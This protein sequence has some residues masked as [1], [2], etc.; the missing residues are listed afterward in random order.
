MIIVVFRF[1]LMAD[2]DLKKFET[3]SQKMGE[4]VSKMAGFHGVKDFSAQDGEIVVIA[5][6]DSL[7]SVDTWKS[8]PKHQAVQKLGKEKFFADYQIQV[9][10]LIRTQ[11]FKV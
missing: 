1:H 9:C 10:D 3:L 7:E 6:F 4:I 5:E 2:A 8:H 11:E